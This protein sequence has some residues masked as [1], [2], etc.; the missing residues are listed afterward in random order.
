[1]NKKLIAFIFIVT[2]FLMY[3]KIPSQNLFC[4]LQSDFFNFSNVYL[5]PYKTNIAPF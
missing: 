3:N 1:M 4:V 2:Y 5:L